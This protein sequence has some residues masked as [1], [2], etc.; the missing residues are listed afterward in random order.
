[1][2]RHQTATGF[3]NPGI[4]MESGLKP[5]IKWQLGPRE[6]A[7]PFLRRQRLDEYAPRSVEPDITAIQTPAADAI[8]I[9]WIGHSTFLIQVDGVNILTD[10]IFSRRC[11]PLPFIGPKRRARPGLSLKKLPE[12]HLVLQSHDHYD[13]LDARTVRRLGNGPHYFTPAG[14]EQWFRKRGLTRVAEL[15]WWQS[16][17]FNNLKLHAVP[18]QHFS[19][20][21]PYRRNA[22]LWCGWVIESSLGNIYFAGDSGY[23]PA[24]KEIGE[25]FKR[26]KVAMIPIGAYRPRWLMSPVH[27]DPP[28]AVRIHQDVNA[29]R[30]VAMHWGTFR[31]TD[32][33]LAEPPVYL[34]QAVR[35]AGLEQGAFLVPAFGESLRF[36]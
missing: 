6:K 10:P 33:P 29:E 35:E 12:I 18:A 16:A 32:E 30:S 14:L 2:K 1:M 9:T 22:T 19:G 13:H 28:Q 5:L 7:P 27:V 4:T 15:D 36:S 3:T 25:R 34:R 26:M 17:D 8:Q 24:F 21:N 31:L 11:S 20:R 23:C